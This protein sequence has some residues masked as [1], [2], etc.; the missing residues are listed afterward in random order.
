MTLN[1]MGYGSSDKH[2]GF[3]NPLDVP[4]H[5]YSKAEAAVDQMIV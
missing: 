2:S 4:V 3:N 5:K 1:I